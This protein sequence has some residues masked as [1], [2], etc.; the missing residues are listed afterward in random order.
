MKEDREGKKYRMLK[1]LSNTKSALPG[2]YLA[3]M[4]GT[5][6][7]TIQN[8]VKELNQVL[9]KI[10]VEIDG[11]PGKGYLLKIGNRELFAKYLAEDAKEPASQSFKENVVPTEY[12]DR[13]NFLISRILLHALN[14]KR[15]PIREVDLADELFVSV[16]SLKIYLKDIQNR[17]NVYHLKIR[18]SRQLGIHVVGDEAQIRYCISEYIFNREKLLDIEHSRIFLEHFPQAEIPVVKNVL[19]KTIVKHDIHLTD[20][21]FRNLMIHIIIMIQRSFS[22]KNVHYDLVTKEKLEDSPHFVIA[23]EIIQSLFDQLGIDIKGEA[24]YLTQHLMASQKFLRVPDEADAE[25]RL[26][27]KIILV[28]NQKTSIDLS[29]DSELIM[30]LTIH[31][32]AALKRAEFEM[33]IRNSSLEA[34]KKDYPLAFEMA[35]IASEV[36]E[37]ETDIQPNENEIGFLAIHFGGSIERKK[38]SFNKKNRVIVVCGSSRSTALLVKA[39]LERRFGPL[40]T[41][42]GIKPRY[43][44]TKEMIDSVEYVFTTVLIENIQSPK[45]ILVDLAVLNTSM[46]YVEREI[47]NLKIKNFDLE[48]FFK[49]ELFISNLDAK[50]SEEAMEALTNLMI[51]QGYIDEEIKTQVFEREKMASTELSKLIAIPHAIEPG[52][53]EPA[54]AVGLLEKPI[55]WKEEYVQIIFLLSIPDNLYSH[56]EDV[57]NRLY[58]A[59]VEGDSGASLLKDRTFD[60]LLSLLNR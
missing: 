38:L 34:I 42:V 20:E 44:L 9:K 40:L 10:N 1:L 33:N 32:I 39:K 17:L 37:C 47:T 55:V 19:M 50:S 5:S 46:D 18:F 60:A 13:I 6:R 8:Y 35:I 59:F 57:F 23:D 51:G 3:N 11:Q 7:R 27:Y 52:N 43:E 54:I 4:T 24:L 25:S 41:I 28:I 45:I 58:E 49:R 15:E 31:L 14:S 26:V 53:S 16:S 2:N 21:A 36:I 29:N 22:E 48:C 56:W 30:G 12:Y